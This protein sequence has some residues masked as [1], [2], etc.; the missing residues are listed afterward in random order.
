L[1]SATTERGQEKQ[2]KHIRTAAW[3]ACYFVFIALDAQF[4]E[5]PHKLNVNL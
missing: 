5:E 1:R 4:A 2:Q 3:T